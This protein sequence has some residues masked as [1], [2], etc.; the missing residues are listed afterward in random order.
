MSDEE[1]PWGKGEWA[2]GKRETEGRL[3]TAS[4]LSAR[5]I[6]SSPAPIQI[7][8][9]NAIELLRRVRETDGWKM[10]RRPLRTLG[11]NGLLGR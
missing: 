1:E 2:K 5:R 11:R 7:G 3:R 4:G 6:E 8:A 10:F 9:G